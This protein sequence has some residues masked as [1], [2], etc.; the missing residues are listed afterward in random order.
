MQFS[1]GDLGAGFFKPV[2]DEVGAARDATVVGLAQYLDV[3]GAEFAAHDF[4]TKERRVA[5]D[6]VGG[7]P[8][9]FA[10]PHPRPLSRRRARG[11]GQQG[12]AVFDTGERLEN[13]VGGVAVAVAPAP[14]NIADPDGNAGKFGGEF[15]YFQPEDVVRAG[16]HRQFGAETQ[17]L[18]FD[19]G[20]LLDVAQGFEGQIKEIAGTAGGVENA[21]VVEAEQEGLPGGLGLFGPGENFGFGSGPFNE[22]RLADQR[23]DQ[24]GDGA[25]VGEV[26][27]ERGARGGVEAALEEGAEDGGVDGAPVHVGGGAVQGLQVGCGQRRNI[28]DFYACLAGGIP[29]GE[30][31]A[32]EPG[33]VVVA[34]FAAGLLHGGEQFGDAPGGLVGVVDGMTE[35]VGEDVGR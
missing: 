5:N 21:E 25:G 19:V 22:Q 16:L 4:V 3:F 15:V 17:F 18:R 28:D 7:R 2:G 30:E 34:V 6:N 14:L 35:E 8:H 1:G 27:A 11:E 12:I 33:D 23:V 26:G 20:A 9:G 13:R 24:F 10:G 29:C 31:T 32:V